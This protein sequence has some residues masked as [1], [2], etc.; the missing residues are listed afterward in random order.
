ML[1]GKVWQPL[2]QFHENEGVCHLRALQCSR[3]R[4]QLIDQGWAGPT[5]LWQ[6]RQSNITQSLCDVNRDLQAQ[7]HIASKLKAT[8]ATHTRLWLIF[9]DSRVQCINGVDCYIA[10][11]RQLQ[12][13]IINPY[14]RRIDDST[15][16]VPHNTVS[17]LL[18]LRASEMPS[19]LEM[20]S[21]H[22]SLWH[23]PLRG[24][25]VR[26]RHPLLRPAKNNRAEPQQCSTGTA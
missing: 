19:L 23:L 14:T 15:A 21:C 18:Q 13:G 26:S 9:L 6:P 25:L 12:Q 5:T 4:S 2:L 16:P 11:R 1:F 7:R 17:S 20:E 8:R 10:C 3:F 24:L 22:R